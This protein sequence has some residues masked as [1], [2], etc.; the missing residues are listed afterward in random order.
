MIAAFK[1][2]LSGGMAGSRDLG[3]AAI[4]LIAVALMIL[5][6]PAM[7]VD[8][9]IGLNFGIAIL[10]VMTA[11][12]LRSPLEFSSL[13]T[14]ILIATIFRLSLSITTTRLILSTGEPGAIIRTFGEFVIAGSVV[15]GMVVFFIITVVQLIVIAK[16]SERVA[17]V[18][19]RFTLDAM[20][21]KQMAI[22]AD[23]RNGDIDQDEARRQR[24]RLAQESQLFGAMDGAMK[25]VK[26][27]SLAGIVIILVNLVGGIVVG[28][29][30]RGMAFGDAVQEYSLLTVGDALISQI[31]AL[32]LSLAASVVVTR[33]ASEVEGNVGRD[34][35]AQLSN[36]HRALFMAG[37]LLF[38][39]AF[40]PGFPAVT[41][42]AIAS[43]FL[44][45]AAVRYLAVRKLARP[46]ADEDAAGEGAPAASEGPGE[47][48]DAEPEEPAARHDAHARLGVELPAALAV[49]PSELAALRERLESIRRD[50]VARNGIAC[51]AL[52]VRLASD[53]VGPDPESATGRC[54][55]TI[56]DVPAATFAVSRERLFLRGDRRDLALADIAFEEAAAPLAG[57]EALAVHLD[58]R[59]RERAL[60]AGLD[61]FGWDEAV[62]AALAHVLDTRAG[63][64]LGIQETRVLLGGYED[65][66]AELLKEVLRTSSLQRIA[67]VF[68]RLLEERV[69]LTNMRAVLEALA[70]WGERERDTVMLTEY[71]RLAL[72]R[73]VCHQHA[74]RH[75]G[76]ASRTIPCLLVAQGVEERIR[77]ALRETNVGTYLV[78]DEATSDHIVA[79]MRCEVARARGNAPNGGAAD[80]DIPFVLMTSMDV[81]RYL[82]SLMIR[83]G[84]D[85]AV[86]SHQE[87]DG[88]YNARPIGS[89]ELEAAAAQP[90]RQAA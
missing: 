84:I 6:M 30:Q 37:A 74:T 85:V 39:M 54:A 27:D 7:L 14:V 34:I 82:R 48:A 17:E 80:V 66:Y 78:M 68:R 9:V 76:G 75:G 52:A 28:T 11:I 89:L 72:K 21:G 83:N 22:D 1:A 77:S 4:L 56:D 60:D 8:V 65:R 35:A 67:D 62:Q 47:T 59:D 45:L 18:G 23:L 10:L 88:A 12:Y 44:G 73:Q 16:G 42:I 71:V 33:V 46:E 13:P 20:P 24:A 81:R 31:P 26:G 55:V 41:I 2:G 86:L 53:A 43:L 36:D 5:P 57:T 25:F 19:A 29:I 32:L 79:S 64:F 15:V 51:P 90:E 58:A 63:D 87:L 61:V 40:L 49:D 38:A 70:E 3:V 50:W 69:A